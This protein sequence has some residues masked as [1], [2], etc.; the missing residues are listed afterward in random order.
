MQDGSI[1][2]GCCVRRSIC[3]ALVV[4]FCS[5]IACAGET[6]V[7]ESKHYRVH[8]DLDPDLTNDLTR[9]LDLMYDEYAR[10]LSGF[11]AGGLKLT[12]N[13]HLFE[14]HV[15]YIRFTDNRLPNSGGMFMPGKNAL[16]A[17]FEKS[18][19]TELQRTLQHEAFHQ[20]AHTHISP[21][22]PVWLNE[23]LA[24]VFEE[25]LW[26]GDK[27]Y[28]GQVPPRRLRELRDH[29]KHRRLVPFDRFL[30]ITPED[31]AKEMRRGPERTNQIYTQAWA[32]AQ[33]LVAGTEPTGQPLRPRLLEMLRLLHAGRDSQSV[34]RE[35]FSDN[36]Q[37]FQDRFVSFARAVQPTAEAVAVEQHQILADMLV[38]L[39]RQGTTFT[40]VSEFREHII[41]GQYRMEYTQNGVRWTTDANPVV[42]FS[43]AGGNAFGSGELFFQ[44]GSGPIQDLVCRADHS[45]NLRAKFH[46]R[47]DGSL[48]SEMLLE[49][50][51]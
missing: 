3:V 47:P 46:L 27:F 36:V 42:Y 10:R 30:N 41:R 11:D 15:D 7:V 35:S 44:R 17:F 16:T 33:F 22:L 39:Y 14:R 12:F 29:M 34:F 28:M 51:R 31:W 13:V 8:S 5:A 26:A 25:G 1:Q 49:P 50:V 6:R 45:F 32:M 9:R 19:R 4:V 23:G 18:T 37:G 38:D 43:S 48:D 40:S 21:N 2:N 24:Q 20:F